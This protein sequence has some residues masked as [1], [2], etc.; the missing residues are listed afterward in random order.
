MGVALAVRARIVARASPVVYMV[1]CND[2][3]VVVERYLTLC[4]KVNMSVWKLKKAGELRC[5]YE[6][7]LEGQVAVS[8]NAALLE[9]Q[10]IESGETMRHNS[11]C[12]E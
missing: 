11:S 8:V 3:V 4:M 6:R 2:C 12:E 1:I 5:G 10:G 9:D 7:S